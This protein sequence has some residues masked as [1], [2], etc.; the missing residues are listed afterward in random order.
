MAS[1]DQSFRTPLLISAKSS[2]VLCKF[3][4]RR[5][6]TCVL[7]GKGTLKSFDNQG[8]PI[9]VEGHLTPYVSDLAYKCRCLKR[10]N[11]I[12]K[13]NVHKGVVRICKQA[14]DGEEK[15]F[16]ITHVVDITKHFPDFIVT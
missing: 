9:Y 6:A 11:L 8:E 13:N 3:L 4:N 7:E 14:E 5:D 15:W 1:L 16:N 12:A 10:Q 2:R